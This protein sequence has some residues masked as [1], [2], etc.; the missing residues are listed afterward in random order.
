MKV[1]AFPF[2]GDKS[3][4]LIP[5]GDGLDICEV[6]AHGETVNTLFQIKNGGGHP[7]VSAYAL[8]N[9]EGWETR[10]DPDTGLTYV[11]V[12]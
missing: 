1:R 2:F 4:A 12:H 6:D 3:L 9:P 7:E 8:Q 11:L 10:V 5:N